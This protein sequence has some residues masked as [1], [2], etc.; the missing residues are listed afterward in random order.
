M[1]NK[2]LEK[3]KL[4]QM[5]K[6]EV[7]EYLK[8]KEKLNKKKKNIKIA[9]ASIVCV[10]AVVGLVV[11]SKYS[12]TQLKYS[13]YATYNDD[14]ISEQEY[15][16]YY[17]VV[18]NNWINTYY[19]YLSYYG[20]S[21]TETFSS[22]IYDEETGETW[23]DYFVD[24]TETTIENVK[25][26]KEAAE[27]DNW[28]DEDAHSSY[29]NFIAAAESAAEDYEYSYLEYI[30]G[31]YGDTL[32]KEDFEKLVKGYCF[33]TS[34]ETKKRAEFESSITDEEIED[35]YQENKNQYDTVEYNM[36]TIK[37]DETSLSDDDKKELETKA[38]N[39]L[40]GV[41]SLESFNEKAK[42]YY[43]DDSEWNIDDIEKNETSSA[44]ADSSYSEW[45]YDSS[46]KEGDTIVV[47]N[48]DET[49]YYVL[50]FK[51]RYLNTEKAATY[52]YMSEE[53]TDEVSLTTAKETLQTALDDWT[54]NSGTESGFVKTAEA[55]NGSSVSGTTYASVENAEI[56]DWLFNEERQPGDIKTF[57]EDKNVRIVYFSKYENPE[58]ITSIRDNKTYLL[59]VDWLESIKTGEVK[60]K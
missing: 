1:K 28:M 29:D 21:L 54:L 17:N 36:I 26:V 43:K 18:V 11:G 40:S 50:Y 41:T 4:E 55:H 31:F 37:S 44:Y 8:K 57:V 33:S 6:S 9:M 53:Y 23:Q 46:R 45:L 2:K 7:K 38:T 12:Q 32:T 42:E 30:Q 5:S 52:R 34:Y 56:A 22:Q 39:I 14:N 16:F 20:L 51:E 27:A 59:Y 49:A 13:T 19:D 58:Y 60:Y 25:S 10:A 24:L 47:S 15:T 48:S 35:Y 3:Q